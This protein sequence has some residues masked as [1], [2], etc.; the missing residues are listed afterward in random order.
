MYKGIETPGLREGERGGIDINSSVT[1]YTTTN[2]HFIQNT[3]TIVTQ[4]TIFHEDPVGSVDS[5]PDPLLF[6]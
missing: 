6:S 5:W 1:T 3:R 4:P 2:I